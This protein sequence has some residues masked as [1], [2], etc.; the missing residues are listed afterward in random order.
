ML[1]CF[2]FTVYITSE[3]TEYFSTKSRRKDKNRVELSLILR[4]VNLSYANM[5]SLIHHSAFYSLI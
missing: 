3:D 2:L 4:R 5:S 1:L